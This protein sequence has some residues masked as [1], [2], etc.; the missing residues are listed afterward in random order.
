MTRTA[1]P[2]DLGRQFCDLV[3][4]G[5]ITSGVVYPSAIRELA[6]SY[7]LRNIGGASAGAI[8]AAGAA[9]AEYRRQTDPANPMAGFERLGQL[10]KE[11]GTPPGQGGSRPGPAHSRLFTL[12]APT[13]LSRPVFSVLVGMLNHL[14][15]KARIVFGLLALVR[16]FPAALLVGVVLWGLALVPVLGWLA[17]SDRF[18][19]PLGLRTALGA[20]ALL[21]ALVAVTGFMLTAMLGFAV[22]RWLGRFAR[23]MAEQE[24]GLCTG[25]GEPGAEAPGALTE[26]LH[27]LF[28]EIAAKR[29]DAPLTFGDLRRVRFAETPDQDGVVLQMMTTCLTAGRPFTLPFSENRF[30][31]DPAELG[32]FFP[33]EVI[34][35]MQDHPWRHPGGEDSKADQ[36]AAAFELGGA[37]RPLL[38][39]P[40]PDDLPVIVG[41]RMSLSFPILL[42][43]IP[44]YRYSIQKDEDGGWSPSMQR[45]CFTDGGVCSNLP[46]HLFDSPLP[47]WPTFAVNLREDLP[48]GSPDSDRVVSPQRG[49]SYQGER[50]PISSSPTL[51]GTFSFLSAIVNTM[52]NW[53]DVLQRNASGFKER[54]FT[55]RHTSTEG[56]M[57]L[58]MPVEAIDAMARSGRLAAQA[59]VTTFHPPAGTPVAAD[60][61]QY[62]R[63]VRIRLLLPV[64][65]DFLATL[66]SAT[67]ARANQPAFRRLLTD[68]PPPMGRSFDLNQASRSAGW[69]LLDQAGL[70]A[71]RLAESGAD[72]ET[73]SPRP[74][75]SLRITP[76]F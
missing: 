72:L 44:L 22:W 6:D 26:W 13:R 1:S 11:L 43:A 62:H 39:L 7:R 37:S 69:A 55:V 63:W 8:A 27:A 23:V 25:M 30:Y 32:R 12:F 2:S 35:W 59:I 38:P 10:A 65:Q 73:N 3:M 46:I 66:D 36:V 58:D 24:F 76:T 40:A 68:S 18:T 34:T 50:Y 16:E 5:G 42:S 56:G 60:D 54:V 29:P 61:W 75:G 14:T 20:L 70:A 28:Q 52:Q 49:R 17:G 48:E 31:F 19:A 4:K 67:H 41:V 47:T 21:A 71:Q 64:L 51:Q 15:V 45:L 74:A 9:A 33:E 57:N 53:R